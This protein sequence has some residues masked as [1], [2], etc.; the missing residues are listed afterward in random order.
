MR[1]WK[2]LN[3]LGSNKIMNWMTLFRICYSQSF[4][5]S[6][7][8]RLKVVGFFFYVFLNSPLRL[9]Y[10]DFFGVGEVAVP[11]TAEGI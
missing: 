4:H 8:D 7:C 10:L 1:E 3:R 2:S 5:F 9:F 6:H 11:V